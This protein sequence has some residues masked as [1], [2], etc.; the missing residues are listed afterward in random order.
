MPEKCEVDYRLYLLKVNKKE[1]QK[2][3]L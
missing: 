3:E 2:Q 1:E